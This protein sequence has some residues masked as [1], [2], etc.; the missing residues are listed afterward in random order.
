MWWVAG[1]GLSA[2]IASAIQVLGDF[3]RRGLFVLVCTYA[4]LIVAAWSDTVRSR[5]PNLL[6][7]PAVLLGLA[8]NCAVAPLLNALGWDWALAW[9]GSPGPAQS[10]LGFA[11][12][13]AFGIISFIARPGGAKG[14]GG[15]DVKVFSAVGAFIGL[16]AVTTVFFNTLCIAAIIGV[17]NW[18]LRGELIAR[19]QVVALAM[20]Q[21]AVTRKDATAI[22]PFK[23]K[24]APFCLSLILG[25]IA[26]HFVAIHEIVL[27]WMGS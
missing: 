21:F 12:C 19:I 27:Q 6:T 16:A 9:L 26:S 5:I 25:L 18:A 2:A 13:F 14:L 17:L 24:H 15:G 3:G 4:F 11:V 7:Y 1:L 23:P 8:I 22:Y 20:V 10:A